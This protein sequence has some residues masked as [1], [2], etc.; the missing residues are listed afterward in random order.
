[1]QIWRKTVNKDNDSG[2]AILTK[3]QITK[4]IKVWENAQRQNLCENQFNC[5]GTTYREEGANTQGK[6]WSPSTGGSVLSPEWTT[7]L[8]SKKKL[9]GI[10]LQS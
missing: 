7:V 4:V 5:S 2:I 3:R 1:M 9:K 8:L 6:G 10:T